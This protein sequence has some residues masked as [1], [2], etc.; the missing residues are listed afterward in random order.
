MVSVNVVAAQSSLCIAGD[1]PCGSDQHQYVVS[2]SFL[3]KL[4][5]TPRKSRTSSWET[6]RLVN[7]PGDIPSGNMC[8][9]IIL[10][11]GGIALSWSHKKIALNPTGNRS[12]EVCGFEIPR[13]TYLLYGSLV[14]GDFCQILFA[15]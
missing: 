3:F 15:P 10:H 12:I 5:L 14:H 8:T 1:L 2:P 4:F 7:I 6:I 9:P 11:K 13:V